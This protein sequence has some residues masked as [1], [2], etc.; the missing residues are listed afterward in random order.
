MQERAAALGEAQR[1]DC[2]TTH[3][4]DLRS[5]VSGAAEFQQDAQ[6]LE[7]VEDPKQMSAPVFAA[8]QAAL[9]RSTLLAAPA[10]ERKQRLLH[11]R[12]TGHPTTFRTNAS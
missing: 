1:P 7:E 6:L 3:R 9:I 12:N 10:S 5:C 4:T 8:A 11:T 2:L